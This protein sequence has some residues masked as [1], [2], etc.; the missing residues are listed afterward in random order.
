MT[1]SALRGI[2]PLS[3]RGHSPQDQFGRTEAAFL[4][5]GTINSLLGGKASSASSLVQEIVKLS[6]AMSVADAAHDDKIVD[7]AL[8]LQA[9]CAALLARLSAKLDVPLDERGL[10]ACLSLCAELQRELERDVLS[11]A[12]MT[13]AKSADF[14][15]KST[16]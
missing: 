11:V 3:K 2:L 10:D 16:V 12:T 6:Q 1:I 7:N 14:S 4:S 13:M 15:T 5:I 9:N 8:D